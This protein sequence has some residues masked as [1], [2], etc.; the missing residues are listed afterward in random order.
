MPKT[1]RAAAGA[2]AAPM[3]THLRSQ[4]CACLLLSLQLQLLKLQ[5]E[6][7]LLQGLLLLLLQSGYRAL[8]ARWRRRW[9]RQAGRFMSRHGHWRGALATSHAHQQLCILKSRCIASPRKRPQGSSQRV[10]RQRRGSLRETAQTS[11]KLLPRQTRRWA[12]TLGLLLPCLPLLLLLLP[13]QLS[14]TMLLGTLRVG[15]IVL[16]RLGRTAMHVV[17]MPMRMVLRV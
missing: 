13:V 12:C 17:S 7:C 15:W 2:P 9:W 8:H 10:S 14:L 5:R 1:L 4:Q 3:P 6:D 11:P 16:G